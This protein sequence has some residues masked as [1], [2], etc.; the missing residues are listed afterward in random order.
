MP[1]SISES[2][3]PEHLVADM[4]VTVLTPIGR[5]GQ[6]MFFT[7][8][9]TVTAAD[10]IDADLVDPSTSAIVSSATVIPGF[11]FDPSSVTTQL[12]LGLINNQGTFSPNAF[13]NQ[14]AGDGASVQL[15]ITYFLSGSAVDTGTITGYTHDA[16][17]GL[18]GLFRGLSLSN[19][20]DL[21]AILNAVRQN[22]S[23][24]P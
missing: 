8:R 19:N 5:I 4:T 20:A 12:E 24:L 17:T 16:V 9:S 1:F 6:G 11:V 21:S 23:N 10:E 14:G 2:L 15:Q 3:P 13:I 22:F 7:T 18:T